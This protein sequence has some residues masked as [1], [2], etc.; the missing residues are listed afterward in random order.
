ML[1]V[2]K[3]LC[4][5]CGVCASNCPEQAISMHSGRAEIDEGRCRECYVC[6]EVCP[7]G[8]ITEQTPI[9]RKELQTTVASLKEKTDDLIERI[10]KIRRSRHEFGDVTNK[11][12]IS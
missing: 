2:K 7:Q 10:E 1:R 6:V 12:S 8:A 3:E 5:G 4:L 9:S 11:E